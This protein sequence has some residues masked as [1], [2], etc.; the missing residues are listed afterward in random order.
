[1]YINAGLIS[2][3]GF[4]QHGITSTG[5]GDLTN[6]G[7]VTTTGGR[8]HGLN[9]LS[10]GGATNSSTGEITTEEN[11]SFGIASGAASTGAISNDGTIRTMGE[12][13]HGISASG[14]GDVT[15][16]DDGRI[17]TTGNDAHGIS[18]IGIGDI[19]NEGEIDSSGQGIRSE[20]NS[21]R[22]I[23]RGA[24]RSSEGG[25]LST[26]MATIITNAAGGRIT[27]SGGTGAHGIS[28]TGSGDINNEGEITSSGQG[29]RSE[30]NS[31]Q[32][33]NSGMIRSDGIGIR[34]EGTA[35]A[36]TN[37]SGGMIT[38]TGNDAHGISSIGSGDINNEGEI[39]SSGQGIRS[40][41]NSGQIINRGA[42]RSSESGIVASGLA[43][44]VTNAAGG[45]ITTSGGVDPHGILS[46]G[47]GNI[48]NEGEIDSSGHGINS[49][50]NSGQIRNAGAIRS[51][52]QGIRSRGMGATAI[53]NA[54]SGRIT[55]SGTDAHGISSIGTGDISNEGEIDSSG[56]GIRSEGNSGQITNSGMIRSDGIGIRSEGMAT[57]ITNATG[58]RIITTGAD[59]HGISSTGTGDISNEG[60]IDSSGH[61]INSEGN[62]DEI[63]NSGMIRS[64]G[65]GIRSEG[66]AT[67]IT[68]ASGGRITTTGND[69]HGISSIGTGDISN[70][71]EID[72]SGQGIRSEGNNNQIT[73]SGTIRS[74]GIGIFS[75]GEETVITNEAGSRII[76][77]GTDAHGISSMSNGAITN[78]GEI[79]V[80]GPFSDGIAVTGGTGEIMNTR[81]GRITSTGHG[82]DSAGT[83]NITNDGIITTSSGFGIRSTRNVGRITNSGTINSGGNGISSGINSDT[84]VINAVGGVITT[85]SSSSHGISSRGSTGTLR[86]EGTITTEGSAASGISAVDGTNE[87][88]NTGAIITFGRGII[89]NSSGNISNT[90]TITTLGGEAEGIYS[91]GNNNMISNSGTINSAGTGIRSEGSDTVITNALGGAI[92]TSG[93]NAHGISS[94]G[95]GDVTN[96][97]TIDSSG[98]GIRSTGNNNMITNSGRIDS[99]GS[100]IHSEGTDTII[101][102]TS[103][104]TITTTGNGPQ[105]GNEASGIF[106]SGNGDVT[107]EGTITTNGINAYAITSTAS[108][109]GNIRN[110]GDIVTNGSSAHA[111]RHLGAGDITNAVGGLI[112]TTSSGGSH[113]IVIVAGSAGGGT[114]RNEGRITTMGS[115]ARGI[116]SGGMSDIINAGSI[117]TDGDSAFG[118][119]TGSS[120]SG[121][122]M[123]ES[124]GRIVTNGSSAHGMN[125]DGTSDIINAGH[126]ETRGNDAI[127]I[128]SNNNRI[129]NSGM[130]TTGGRNSHGIESRNNNGII[131][132]TDTGRIMTTGPNAHGIFSRGGAGTGEISNEGEI[133][134]SGQGIRSEGND[135]RITNRG[136][137]NSV[138]D[139]IRSEGDETEI[140]NEASGTITVMKPP[141]S[142]DVVSGIS[143]AGTGAITN[144]GTIETS[145]DFTA[146]IFSERSRRIRNTR[147]I[148]TNGVFADGI[149]T[150]G[151]DTVV[152]NSGIIRINSSESELFTGSGI[153]STGNGEITNTSTGRIITAGLGSSGIDSSGTGDITNEGEII[154]SGGGIRSTGNTDMVSN[155]IR[156]TGTITTSGGNAVGIF[157]GGFAATIIN[158]PGSTIST[159]GISSHGIHSTAMGSISNEGTIITTGDL[160]DGI[161][162]TGKNVILGNDGMPICGGPPLMEPD[163]SQSPPPACPAPENV[164][165]R[166]DGTINTGGDFADGIFSSGDGAEITVGEDGMITTTGENAHGIVALGNSEITINGK[167]KVSTRREDGSYVVRGSDAEDQTLTLGAEA[168]IEGFSDL[169]ERDGDND[170]LDIVAKTPPVPRPSQTFAVSGV[171]T[172]RSGAVPVLQSSSAVAV[173]DPTGSSA[174][175]IALGA[176]TG[177]IRRQVFQRLDNRRLSRGAAAKRDAW[178]GLFGMVSDRDEDELALAWDHSLYGV[179]GGVDMLL[180]SGQRVGVFAGV[181]RNRV[182]TKVTSIRDTATH[183]FVGAYG[184]Q[185]IGEF[186][187]DGAVLFGYGRHDS[188]RMVQDTAT[189]HEVA[190]GKY[191]NF[192]VSPS[193]SLKWFKGLGEGL[194]FRPRAEIS[195][196]YGDFSSHTERDTTH[197]NISFSG[198]NV[199]IA[200]GRLEL[201]LARTF[202][203]DQGEIEVRGGATLTHFGRDNVR[204]RLEDGPSISYRVTGEDTIRG[205]FGGIRMRYQITDL[206]TM[207]GDLEYARSSGDGESTGGY[208]WLG[209]QF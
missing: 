80:D 202:D 23:N 7:T 148:T 155:T 166:N 203:D 31:G 26:G 88:I 55:T 60:E 198:R 51:V 22:I 54:A 134:S 25:I 103:G 64:G 159:G 49:L 30:G 82:I 36:I 42:I 29:I 17:T 136:T 174:T 131:T 96:E 163:G 157:S 90:G 101:I 108:S 94:I 141:T 164:M 140:I 89:S 66:M 179:S 178:G 115:G 177:Q 172:V 59:A 191:D 121:N 110:E 132:N 102:N 40:E 20:G 92:I 45:T 165:I 117:E 162:S 128:R 183:G 57:I 68:N 208:M 43:T 156:N 143:S 146:G 126:I 127:G 205:G 78:E 79:T 194:E 77:D 193:L 171:D 153:F 197:S 170:V 91:R 81:T 58:G 185:S 129:T 120:S 50:G 24:I 32:I 111:I 161:V 118:I 175:R 181:G 144:N 135:N 10:G 154:S 104:S 209:L 86:N 201:A 28:S 62:N 38:T 180:E 109:M 27:A 67:A 83:G 152:I 71:G 70:E 99:V 114:V 16:D 189:G 6:N 13:S 76:T 106:F 46:T 186:S 195:Y 85:R 19:S 119:N 4:G 116:T 18:S 52:G 34:S 137:I 61:G 93:S 63:T 190:N 5:A 39:T 107:N 173:L 84:E 15:N 151:D 184:Q 182:R 150:Q 147:T 48:T 169:G 200:D 95:R 56:Q 37:A 97:G 2:T 33:T 41:G 125:I 188:D 138:G 12:E 72:S 160:A 199:G 8:S 142:L 35:T 206:I 130:I 53:T 168:I 158:A 207:N 196:T 124:S 100:G 187:L 122:I 123:N 133:D 87:I 9:I 192:Y 145:G 73:N 176:M 47:T 113:G 139:G 149:V 98:Q 3:S 204:A 65:I 44:I 74:G 14:S 69:A 11:G 75:E 167:V 21:G 105:A 112:A 1:M